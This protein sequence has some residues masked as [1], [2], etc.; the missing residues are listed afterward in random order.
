MD[1]SGLWTFWMNSCQCHSTHKAGFRQYLQSH[2]Y[3]FL[4]LV[5]YRFLQMLPC[6]VILSLC[7]GLHLHDSDHLRL[8]QFRIVC[9]AELL[10][11]LS[12]M[13]LRKNKGDISLPCHIVHKSFSQSNSSLWL[14]LS[15]LNISSLFR[16][17]PSSRNLKQRQQFAPSQ[18]FSG[19]VAL[20]KSWLISTVVVLVKVLK[21]H[22]RILLNICSSFKTHFPKCRYTRTSCTFTLSHRPTS[23]HSP[24]YSQK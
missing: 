3:I 8:V 24:D 18:C 17:C 13:M 10:Q 9:C 4:S 19:C 7:P 5:V 2:V 22:C 21:A 1:H 11:W 12:M 20:L 6:I 16:L 23:S 14:S 15:K